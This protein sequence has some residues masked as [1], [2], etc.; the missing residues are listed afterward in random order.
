MLRTAVPIRRRIRQSISKSCLVAAAGP[1]AG[2]DSAQPVGRPGPERLRDLLRW[3]PPHPV[4]PHQ[5][6]VPNYIVAPSQP[7]YLPGDVTRTLGFPPIRDWCPTSDGLQ[8]W[9]AS[10]VFSSAA[11]CDTHLRMAALCFCWRAPLIFL[12]VGAGSGVH[13]FRFEATYDC[14]LSHMLALTREFDLLGTWNRMALDPAILGEPSLFANIVYTGARHLCR[15]LAYRLA[16]NAVGSM[17]RRRRSQPN[18]GCLKYC[19]HAPALEILAGAWDPT[20]PGRALG[21]AA[22]RTLGACQAFAGQR[23]AASHTDDVRWNPRLLQGS[24]CPSRSALWTWWSAPT[25]ATCWR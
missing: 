3:R 5:G 9:H 22:R 11:V 7:L 8:R 20:Q 23:T 6:W 2:P 1:G 4:P 14:P 15:R 25:G 16:C 13:S 12:P 24:G 19:W 21:S 10:A 17:H 18:T